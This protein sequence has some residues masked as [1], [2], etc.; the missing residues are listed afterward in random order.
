MKDCANLQH[1]LAATSETPNMHVQIF[2]E[3][4]RPLRDPQ[5]HRSEYRS[6]MHPAPGEKRDRDKKTGLSEVNDSL[7]MG[8]E[9]RRRWQTK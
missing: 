3:L 5:T 4:G 9:W 2:K 6:G 1:R 7:W 8:P